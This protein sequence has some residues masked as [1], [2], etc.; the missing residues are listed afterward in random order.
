VPMINQNPALADNIWNVHNIAYI[1]FCIFIT[2]AF[3][4]SARHQL[5]I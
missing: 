3:Y 4:A 1:L 5:T 2:K